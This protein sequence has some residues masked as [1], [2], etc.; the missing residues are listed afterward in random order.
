M[1]QNSIKPFQTISEAA[2]L[3]GFS[4]FNLR[5]RVREGTIKFTKSG[6]KYL[7][8]IPEL[9]KCEGLTLADLSTEKAT[10]Q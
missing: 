5:K 8:N 1:T 10:E 4:E 9:L 3:T 7:I 2:K 6:C